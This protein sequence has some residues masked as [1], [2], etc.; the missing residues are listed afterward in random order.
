[1][2]L[3]Y[4]MSATIPEYPGYTF[5]KNGT[6]KNRLGQMVGHEGK[7]GYICG[8]W[9]H[10]K[11]TR[12][13]KRLHIMICWAFSGQPQ[14]GRDVDHVNG[15]KKDN[16]YENL[17]YLTRQEHNRKTCS[18]V[19][20]IYTFGRPIRSISETGDVC[21]YSSVTDAYKFHY[22]EKYTPGKCSTIQAAIKRNGKSFGLK[23]EYLDTN[24]LEEEIWKEVRIEGILSKV[25][26]SSEGRI[27]YPN[28]RIMSGRKN[29]D[30]Y[31]DCNV[32]IDGKSVVKKVHQLVCIA[33]HGEP[34]YATSSVNHINKIRHDN[35]ATNLEWDNPKGQAM[36]S[37]AKNVQIIENGEI[38]R[39]FD[40]CSEAASFLKVNTSSLCEAA[41]YSYKCRGYNIVVT[42]QTI[43][44]RR[45][46]T[47]GSP[48]EQYDKNRNLLRTFPSIADACR[49]VKPEAV[50]KR[51]GFWKKAL[52]FS[53]LQNQLCYGYYWKLVKPPENANEIIE[54]ERQRQITKNTNYNKR[55]RNEKQLQKLSRPNINI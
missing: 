41:K 11:G 28:G 17:Q 14:N 24:D 23:W 34:P 18:T 36:K 16:R 2:L 27:K 21:V 1:M 8:T 55:K 40:S 48:I 25:M 7:D 5:F 30:G 15:N 13:K 51:G 39:E 46:G 26:V 38:I 37:I 19:K 12:H 35:H 43:G 20:K 10:V 9:K 47:Q 44:K 29:L 45:G 53:A 3:V 31:M 33:F 49:S 50:T 22:K 54:K 52:K 32:T 42:G 6:A 4:F